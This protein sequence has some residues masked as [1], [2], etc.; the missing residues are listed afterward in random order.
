LAV[1]N[2]VRADADGLTQVAGLP[3]EQRRPGE[4][5]F[6]VLPADD[7]RTRNLELVRTWLTEH[8]ESGDWTEETSGRGAKI[9]MIVHKMTARR[10]GFLNLYAAFH[11]PGSRLGDSF[12]E[13][14][15]WPLTPFMNVILPLCKVGSWNPSTA[16]AILR[17]HSTVLS[18]ESLENSTLG[19]A[20]SA[21]REA[22]AQLRNIVAT[23]GPGSI[24]RALLV[25]FTSGLIGPDPRLSAYLDP[26]RDS[27]DIIHP[28]NLPVLDAFM[29]CDVAELHGYVEYIN[30]RSP[31]STQHGTK[32]SE[33]PR[34]IVVLD[35][36]EGKYPLYSYEKLLG[37]RELSAQDKEN[38]ANGSDSVIERTRR[39][40]YV[41]VSRAIDAL[42]VV[43]FTTD[44]NAAIL[45][46]KASGLPGT[47]ESLTLNELGDHYRAGA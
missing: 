43:M 17:K 34:V 1:I 9:L 22:V 3:T 41:C 6:F 44:V 39:L 30:N 19:V 14:T 32:G 31:Y 36:D 25:A 26:E 33:F 35:D 2:R 38:Q 4:V 24:G 8:S 45:A 46:L 15:A 7:N 18:A 29:Q 10:L 47:E 11:S 20:L 5:Y 21:T 27:S 16:V 37:L 40:L 28:D 23:A 12:N 13:G 42:A